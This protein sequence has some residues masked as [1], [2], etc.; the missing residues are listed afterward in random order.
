MTEGF[1]EEDAGI[2]DELDRGVKAL[3]ATGRNCRRTGG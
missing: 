3:L 2:V 1:I